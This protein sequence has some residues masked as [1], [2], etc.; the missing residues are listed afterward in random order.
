MVFA[1]MD[2]IEIRK[3]LDR[4]DYA[5]VMFLAERMSFIPL[6]AGFKKNNN[7]LCFQ[8]VRE[9]ELIEQKRKLAF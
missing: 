7:L 9:S 2:L 4:I 5:I 8:S 6:V 3:H 1:F